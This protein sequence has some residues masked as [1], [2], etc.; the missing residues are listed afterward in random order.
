MS[1]ASSAYFYDGINGAAYKPYADYLVNDCFS[2]AHIP[3]REVLDLGCGTGAICAILAKKGFDMV[4]V[5]SSLD[6]LN[7]AYDNNSGLNTLLLG[8]DMRSFELYGTVQAV[9][10]SFDCLNYL[11]SVEELKRVF[12][13]VHNYLEPGG[14]FAFDVN[15]L[16]RF[17]NV[18][19]GRTYAY[20]SGGD[21][22]VWR[23][24]LDESG[25]KCEFALDLFLQDADGKYRRESETQTQTFF[26][27]S[28]IIESALGFKLL[29]KTGGKGFDGCETDEKE[30]YLFLRK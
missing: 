1:F 11:S 7:L 20:E 10:S 3:V 14:V 18:F 4:G 25:R 5:D 23:S 29:E 27:Q 24:A 30:Y 17:E 2:R 9:Y 21:M 16:Y 6:M 15:T 13:L 28:Q 19:D 22:I 12:S 8:Q 26:S